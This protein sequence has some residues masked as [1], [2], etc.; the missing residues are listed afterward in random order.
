MNIDRLDDL[1]FRDKRVT[2]VG[3]GKEGVDMA[4]YLASRGAH[5]TVSDAKPAGKLAD[6][7]GEVADVPLR[8]SL[9]A[10][11]PRDVVEADAIFLSQGVPLDLPGLDEA[12]RRGIP[13]HSMLSLFM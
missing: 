6:H 13:V 9:G 12:R 5:V 7:I 4:R 3:L 2:V 11:N 10:N 1:D 8:L